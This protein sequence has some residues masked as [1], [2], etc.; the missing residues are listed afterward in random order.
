MVAAP[1][2]PIGNVL[3]MFGLRRNAKGSNHQT[4]C[5]V[6]ASSYFCSILLSHSF[7]SWMIF[8]DQ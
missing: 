8:H 7:L 5:V 6:E 3:F 1:I 2:E 4:I